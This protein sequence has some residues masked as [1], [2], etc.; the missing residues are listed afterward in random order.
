MESSVWYFPAGD[1][2]Q[3]AELPPASISAP[4]FN[5]NILNSH[6]VSGTVAGTED[7]VVT[8]QTQIPVLVEQIDKKGESI[9]YSLSTG[10]KSV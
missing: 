10:G 1:T 7:I 3:V 4:S 9:K 2:G 6:H 5:T 8:K